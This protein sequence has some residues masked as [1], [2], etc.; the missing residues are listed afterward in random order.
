MPPLLLILQGRLIISNTFY[1]VLQPQAVTGR[2]PN[3]SL[4]SNS[5]TDNSKYQKTLLPKANA[6]MENTETLQPAGWWKDTWEG[7]GLSRRHLSLSSIH[8]LCGMFQSVSHCNKWI[9][10]LQLGT[11]QTS[12]HWRTSQFS[13]S[14]RSLTSGTE[15]V[16][17]SRKLP[18]EK[19]HNYSP[20]TTLLE[21]KVTEMVLCDSDGW[22]HAR[23]C[24]LT[25][26]SQS[27]CSRL[28]RLRVYLPDS[29]P[30]RLGPWNLNITG[31]NTLCPQLGF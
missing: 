27:T 17:F 22:G 12:E 30:D 29:A 24:Q 10:K 28:G 19:T 4:T 18:Q 31:T 5:E 9:F 21:G 20:A 2:N 3:R 26:I 16:S 1:H 13:V 11:N 23:Q 14:V 15:A 7:I 6:N 8:L 25:E